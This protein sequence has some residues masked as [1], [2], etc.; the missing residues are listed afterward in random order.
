MSNNKKNQVV[1]VSPGGSPGGGE[2]WL[3]GARGS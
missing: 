2:A 3:P 1:K